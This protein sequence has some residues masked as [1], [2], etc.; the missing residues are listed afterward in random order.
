MDGVS[1]TNALTATDLIRYCELTR[2]MCKHQLSVENGVEM[3]A[4]PLEKIEV[5][6][7]PNRKNPGVQLVNALALIQNH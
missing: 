3:L 5:F 7:H 1:V 6:G 2:D 4:T